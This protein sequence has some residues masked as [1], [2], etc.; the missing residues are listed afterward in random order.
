V[1]T[2]LD[3]KDSFHQ[4]RVHHD[5]TKFF[6]FVT[7]DGQYEFKRVPFGYSEAPAKFQKRLIQILNPLIRE[8]K[9]MMYIDDVLIPSDSIV[10]NL[11]TLKKVLLLLK[12]I[13]FRIKLSEMSIL[14]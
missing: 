6:A 1:F 7:P 10:E 2:V 9:I 8:E 3:L 12:K 13:R 4:I 5:L 11:E 14:V